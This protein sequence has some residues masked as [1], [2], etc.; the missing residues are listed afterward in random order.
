MCVP[1]R[2]W[3]G[4]GERAAHPGVQVS[5]PPVSCALDDKTSVWLCVAVCMAAC[6]AVVWLCGCVAVWLRPW[7]RTEMVQ[8]PR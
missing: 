4:S 3:K 7:L 2:A 5:V 8:P 6:V 1:S